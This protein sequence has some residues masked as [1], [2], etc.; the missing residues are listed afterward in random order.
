MFSLDIEELMP[1]D[2]LAML[3]IHAGH[4]GHAGSL[5]GKIGGALF[6]FLHSS[7]QLFGCYGLLMV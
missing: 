7:G 5:G 6:F 2:T 1:V 3:A 4:P